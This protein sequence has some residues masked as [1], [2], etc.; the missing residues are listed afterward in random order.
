[1]WIDLPVDAQVKLLNGDNVIFKTLLIP[2]N[3]NVLEFPINRTVNYASVP[4]EFFQINENL[5]GSG[6]TPQFLSKKRDLHGDCRKRRNKV[7]NK[8]KV[9]PRD[10]KGKFLKQSQTQDDSGTCVTDTKP[11]DRKGHHDSQ[12]S[13][14]KKRGIYKESKP[15][16]AFE[17]KAIIN[18]IQSLAKLKES[19]T[20][21]LNT[22]SMSSFD[23][24]F[25]E[26][27][28]LY[29]EQRRRLM[30][31]NI[32]PD[33]IK[34]HLSIKE[35]DNGPQKFHKEFFNYTSEKTEECQRTLSLN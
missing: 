30:D 33:Q 20:H 23:I 14:L 2:P 13:L 11:V 24:N 25:F 32:F 18:K 7:V 22:K 17:K 12:N 9:Q 3:I 35:N 15:D 10:K 26:T 1:M 27:N 19:L 8:S 31:S 21:V 6:N 28:P 29:I 4:K 16:A 34:E 5:M